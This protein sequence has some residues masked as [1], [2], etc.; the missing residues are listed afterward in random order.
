MR[1]FDSARG[2]QPDRGLP[3]RQ[4]TSIALSDTR[5]CLDKSLEFGVQALG[6]IRGERIRALHRGDG[7]FT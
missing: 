1:T 4:A 5:I 2:P 7:G 6:L 3:T